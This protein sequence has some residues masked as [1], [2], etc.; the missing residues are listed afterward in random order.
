MVLIVIAILI[1][2]IALVGLAVYVHRS[3]VEHTPE[4]KRPGKRWML[5]REANRDAIAYARII[6]GY[7]VQPDVTV[8]FDEHHIIVIKDGAI[9]QYSLFPYSEKRLGDADPPPKRARRQPQP[10]PNGHY[11]DVP[12]WAR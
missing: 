10:Q 1:N 11:D 9:T 5:S 6:H 8:F 2:A 4:E 7:A 12:E 3:S